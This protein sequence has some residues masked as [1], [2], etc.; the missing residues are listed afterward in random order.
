M[1]MNQSGKVKHNSNSEISKTIHS[2]FTE[3]ETNSS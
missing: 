1:T 3:E 2:Y